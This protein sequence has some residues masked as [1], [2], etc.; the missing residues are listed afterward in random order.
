MIACISALRTLTFSFAAIAL[1]RRD[2]PHR[3]PGG[4][5]ALAV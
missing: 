3:H 2:S 4:L 1:G 5:M